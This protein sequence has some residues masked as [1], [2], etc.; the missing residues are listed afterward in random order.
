[1]SEESLSLA[2]AALG[3]KERTVAELGSWLRARGVGGEEAD[4]V[5]DR[6][7]SNGTLDD[8]RFAR[9]YA[10]D[11]RELK[12]WGSER[13]R[14]ALLDR[15]IAPEDIE[16]ALD[17]A[18]AEEEVERAI[19]L[20]RE[21]GATLADALERQKALGLLIRRGYQSE[22]AYEAVRRAQPRH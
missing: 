2:L 13:I 15:G 1:M 7:V 3:R 10:E 9:R 6:L 11:K 4:D 8:A 18:G 12:R 21:R 14:T 5:V 17:D 19:S 20:L 22:T 16:H